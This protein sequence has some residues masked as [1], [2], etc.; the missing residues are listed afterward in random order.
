MNSGKWEVITKHSKQLIRKIT[1]NTRIKEFFS[2]CNRKSPY[3]YLTRQY[4]RTTIHQGFRKI[5]THRHHVDTATQCSHSAQRKSGNQQET[6]IISKN[7][8]KLPKK[9]RG[10]SKFPQRFHFFESKS[11][12]HGSRIFLWQQCFRHIQFE[13]QKHPIPSTQYPDTGS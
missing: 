2:A 11:H 13:L 6:W 4:E 12:R 10:Y 9:F 1:P 5:S 7:R 8:N 3:P